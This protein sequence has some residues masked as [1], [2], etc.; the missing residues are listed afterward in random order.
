MALNAGYLLESALNVN[1][2]RG[3]STHWDGAEGEVDN[4][5]KRDNPSIRLLSDLPHRL[6]VGV[7]P[8]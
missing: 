8:L 6:H 1:D 3:I 7:E 2:A 4:E 5:F